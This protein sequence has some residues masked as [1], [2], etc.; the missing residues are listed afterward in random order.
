MAAES[1]SAEDEEE[2]MWLLPY[3]HGD[4]D[5]EETEQLLTRDG[6]FLVRKGEEVAGQALLFVLSLLVVDHVRHVIFRRRR[7]LIAVDFSRERGFATISDF[8]DAHLERNDSISSRELVVIRRGIRRLE[9]LDE[10][11]ICDDVWLDTFIWLGRAE[12]VTKCALI[13]ARFSSLVDVRLKAR[14]WPMGELHVRRAAAGTG[15]EIRIPKDDDNNNDDD[16]TNF[17]VLPIAN[18]PLPASI[19]GIKAL[20][21]W[22]IDQEVINFLHHMRRLFRSD[23]ALEFSVL[24]T[25]H[26]SWSIMARQIWPLIGHGVDTLVNMKKSDFALL[27]EHISPTVLLDYV[28]LRRIYTDM[29]PQ[30]PTDDG[31]ADIIEPVRRGNN[32]EPVVVTNGRPSPDAQDLYAWLHVLRTDGR[33]KV[34]RLA[35]W[36][37]PWARIRRNLKKTFAD[38]S[39]AANFIIY[40]PVPERFTQR[41][42]EVNAQTRERLAL[43]ARRGTA[44]YRNELSTNAVLVR[45]PI[46]FGGRQVNKWED[47]ANELFKNYINISFGDEDIGP[48]SSDGPSK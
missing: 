15:A 22:Y 1:T 10:L 13:N 45:C 40:S 33:P 28:N 11:D 47:G 30:C 35:K 29:Y 21:I 27:R 34:L 46:D 5:R 4:L 36:K 31:E 9:T 18:S 2:A 14:K 37:T 43:A 3:Y 12:V 19:I 32:R 26:R 7:G 8:V 24:P 44:L 38:A 16:G 17:E 25:Q 39:T 48:L 20:Y 23:I 6:D 41:F 42:N